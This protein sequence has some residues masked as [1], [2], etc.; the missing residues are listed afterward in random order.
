MSVETNSVAN[1]ERPLRS[2]ESKMSETFRCG[3]KGMIVA[4]I[5]A[6]LFGAVITY[7]LLY[8]IVGNPM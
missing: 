7:D 4:S 2:T 1:R 5:L 6:A 3:I 8:G